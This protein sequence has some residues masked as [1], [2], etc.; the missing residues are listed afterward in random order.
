MTSYKLKKVLEHIARYTYPEEKIARFYVEYVAK[1]YSTVNANYH[2]EKKRIRI[3]NFSR[4][5]I[6]ILCSAIHELT[7]HICYGRDGNKN[8]DTQF[9]IVFKELLSSAVELGYMDYEECRGIDDSNTIRSMEMKLGKVQSKYNE[10]EDPNKQY[11]TM[12]IVG[13]YEFRDYLLENK[14]HYSPFERIWEKDIKRSNKDRYIREILEY[15]K[16][17]NITVSDINDLKMNVYYSVQVTGNTYPYRT[18]FT[19]RNYR[20]KKGIWYKRMEASQFFD[21][22]LFLKELEGIEFKIN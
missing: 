16:N 15:D 6:N 2:I 21:E 17:A 18:K 20:Y 22:Y 1:E 3:Y 13:G 4:P 14:F 9:Y 8:H 5:T 19:E 7:H 12:Q 11:C 10:K